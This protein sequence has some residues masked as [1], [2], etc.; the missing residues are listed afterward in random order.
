MCGLSS[1]SLPSPTPQHAAK[2][3]SLSGTIRP[4]P[5]V[6]STRRYAGA[7]AQRAVMWEA[8]R[9]HRTNLALGPVGLKL[10]PPERVERD[11][12][13]AF[14]KP[15]QEV[16]S[17]FVRRTRMPLPSFVELIR[18]QSPDVYRPNKNMI[19]SVLRAACRD[20]N[21]LEELLDIAQCGV[22]VTLTQPMPRQHSRPPDHK[23]AEERYNILVKNILHISPFGVVDKGRE[24]PQIFG[25]T[26]TR[27]ANL[28]YTLRYVYEEA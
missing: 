18:G 19:P 14:N 28:T 13:F 12:M 9:L 17:E 1:G 6:V 25:R 20:Y 26:R 7:G 4:P 5:T 23:S 16:L 24:D 10:P 15:L 2:P 27:C 3:L 22:R 8:L 21:H 11:G